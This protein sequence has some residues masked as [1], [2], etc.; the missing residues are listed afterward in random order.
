MQHPAESGR[1]VKLLVLINL[2]SPRMTWVDLGFINPNHLYIVN[3]IA[4]NLLVNNRLKNSIYYC[5]YIR[6]Y[7]K[8][9]FHL[10]FY[11]LPF[12]HLFIHLVIWSFGAG[13]WRI[14]DSNR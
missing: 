11:H 12:G 2:G 1:Y 10:P 8:D 9:H 6:Q 4:F 13:Q 14:T 7:V 5:F 3:L